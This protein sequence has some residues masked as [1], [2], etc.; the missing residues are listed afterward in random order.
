VRDHA[1]AVLCVRPTPHPDRLLTAAKDNSVRI[2]DFRQLATLQVR[3]RV[4]RLLVAAGVVALGR[5][6]RGGRRA[7]CVPPR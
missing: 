1:A 4:W 3:Q 2:W 7:G 6:G 5:R